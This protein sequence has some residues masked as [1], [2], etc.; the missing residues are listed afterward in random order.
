MG[1]GKGRG[2]RA[3]L[4]VPEIVAASRRVLLDGGV[5]GLTMRRL[6]AELGVTGMSLYTYFPSRE[7]LLRHVADEV[8]G[9]A[10]LPPPDAGPWPE[11]IRRYL[12]D[13]ADGFARYPGLVRFVGDTTRRPVGEQGRRLRRELL[14]IL[15]DAG[16]DPAGA[17]AAHASLTTLMHGFLEVSVT[18]GDAAPD[19]GPPE[20][21]D[22][23][24]GV[25]EASAALG[26]LDARARFEE[27]LDLLLE[28]LVA[29]AQRG[30]PLE[31]QDA[32]GDASG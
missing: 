22:D 29:R 32:A 24:P 10:R 28:A 1:D 3:T 31:P 6:G 30:R 12:L 2:R 19:A 23:A 9:S 26:A 21:D 13:I 17:A 25:A 11:R 27:A 14:G 5:A 7:D 15:L 18:A 20:P 4:S 8:I 16:F